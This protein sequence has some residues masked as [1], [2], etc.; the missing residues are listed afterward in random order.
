[1]VWKIYIYSRN[2]SNNNFGSYLWWNR[3]ESKLDYTYFCN[4]VLIKRG[5]NKVSGIEGITLDPWIKK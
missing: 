1:M 2:N 4:K 5:V 3:I